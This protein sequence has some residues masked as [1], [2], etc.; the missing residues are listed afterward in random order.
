MRRIALIAIAAASLAGCYQPMRPSDGHLGAE[1][2]GPTGSIP[3]PVALSA[4]VPKPRPSRKAETYSV[5]VNNVRVPELLFALARDAKLNVDIHPGITGTVTLNAIDQTLPQLLNRIAKQVD[6]RWELD[7][8]NLVVMPDSP[9]L[10]VYKIDYV[11]MER[12]TTGSVAVSGQITGTTA[13]GG[14]GGAAGG[15]GTTTGAANTSTVTVRNSSTNRFWDTLIDNI[16]DILRETDKILPAGPVAAVPPPQAAGAQAGA[17]APGPAAAA[18]AGPNVAYREAASVIAN[19]EAGVLSIRATSRQHEKIQEFLDQVMVSARRQVLIEATIVEVRLSNAYNQGIDWAF[20]RTGLAGFNIQQQPSGVVTASPPGSIFTLNYTSASFTATIKL[21]ET[22]G[23]V[24]VLSSPRVSVVNNQTAILKVVDNKVYFT[25]SS[26]TTQAQ[27]TSLTTFTTTPNVVPVGLVMNVTPSIGEADNVIFN[28]KPTVSRIV[29][30][31]N[32]PNPVLAAVNVVS[33]IPEIQTR[34]I[35]SVMKVSS[36][37]IAVMGGLIQDEA[38]NNEDFVPWVNR[39]PV[40][41]NLFGNRTLA[42]AKS[43]L[44]IFLRPVVIRDASVDGDFR[45]YRQY[46]PGEDFMNEPNPARRGPNGEIVR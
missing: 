30:Y 20:L 18:P 15:T 19:R 27:T 33:R 11:N 13:A 34:E 8:P 26:Q 40:I 6:M 43:E 14:A 23:N 21:L 10:R 37:Q 41:G 1:Q 31:V 24:R 25:I 9:Y 16:S 2:T 45:D 29:G 4:A 42:S 3:P 28:V 22:F 46:L 36:G 39:I 32:D 35:E 12:S 5:V 17:G 7:G 38:A 44:V